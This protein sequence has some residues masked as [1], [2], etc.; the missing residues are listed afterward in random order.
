MLVFLYVPY[1]GTVFTI[2]IFTVQYLFGSVGSHRMHYSSYQVKE[3]ERG[4]REWGGGGRE[5]GR[6]K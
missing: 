3:G 5:G 2:H 4:G 1:T 6:I